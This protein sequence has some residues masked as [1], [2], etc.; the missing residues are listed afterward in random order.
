M[1][2]WCYVW[3]W[4]SESLSSPQAAVPGQVCLLQRG[5]GPSWVVPLCSGGDH[6]TLSVLAGRAGASVTSPDGPAESYWGKSSQ[7]IRPVIS[8]RAAPAPGW[9]RV[10]SLLPL[11][12]T[13]EA[14]AA[15]SGVLA[16]RCWWGGDAAFAP[17][18]S[19]S[20]HHLQAVSVGPCSEVCA[21]LLNS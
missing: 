19:P 3:L 21:A 14:F 7:L 4:A 12:S 17:S 16:S 11:C 5:S 13:P 10:L 15:V 20:P 9:P 1:R 6:V 18:C 8:W 2:T